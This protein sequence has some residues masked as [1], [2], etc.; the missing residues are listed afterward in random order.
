MTRTSWSSRWDG[1]GS[2]WTAAFLHHLAARCLAAGDVVGPTT[3]RPSRP[4]A[5]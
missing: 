3:A 2:P 5:G 1:Q 4:R